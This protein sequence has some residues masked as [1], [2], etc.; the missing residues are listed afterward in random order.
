[1]HG[2]G[3]GPAGAASR[4]MHVC[5]L[6]DTSVTPDPESPWR[7]GTTQLMSTGGTKRRGNPP[8]SHSWAW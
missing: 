4:F 3:L 1:M 7:R 6:V 2:P 5:A 8:S